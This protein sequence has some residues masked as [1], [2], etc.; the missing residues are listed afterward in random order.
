VSL[1]KDWRTWLLVTV[2]FFLFLGGKDM[3]S[4]KVRAL[5]PWM[6]LPMFDW[7]NG[8]LLLMRLHAFRL[9]VVLTAGLAGWILLSESSRGITNSGLTQFLQFLCWIPVAVLVTA[10]A[11]RDTRFNTALCT[12]AFLYLWLV[13]AV[14]AWQ[15]WQMGDPRPRAFGHNVLV[16]SIIFGVFCVCI[17]AKPWNQRKVI[18]G[19]AGLALL[20]CLFTS[21]ARAPVLTITISLIV[22]TLIVDSKHR[23]TW[24]IAVGVAFSA[25]FLANLDR[26]RVF[27]A[28]IAG[29]GQGTRLTS[30]GVRL[31]AWNYFLSAFHQQP[32][33]GNSM[34][35]TQDAFNTF[36]YQS[37][38]KSR[39]TYPYEHL[40]NDSLQLMASYGLP[41]G[42][43]F[44]ALLGS[45][46]FVFIRAAYHATSPAHQFIAFFGFAF[47]MNV[48]LAGF[49]D[50]LTFFGSTQIAIQA[51][52]GTLVALSAGAQAKSPL[53]K[54]AA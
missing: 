27:A 44:L 7:R 49:T 53:A 42:A 21:A 13:F 54:P 35:G 19:F 50:S 11:Q 30:I 24:L 45:L 22:S 2:L 16:G 52:L 46:G 36:L 25:L 26:V 3:G 5:L 4:A 17:S 12:A 41:A 32:M 51:I 37:A 6:L 34:Q 47:V 48:L 43:L 14:M 18:T 1:S 28:D 23:V 10:Q 8:S 33:L 31:D 9:A 40:H 15:R 29:L 39:W 20:A 38:E